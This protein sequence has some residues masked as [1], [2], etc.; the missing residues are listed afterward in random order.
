M[1]KRPR[2]YLGPR[3]Y[4]AEIIDLKT[5]E[6]RRAALANVPGDF[7]ERVAFYVQDHFDKRRSLRGTA[8]TLIHTATRR[9]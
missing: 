3:H 4:A 5:A 9:Y 2:R 7:K 8:I 6:E 1:Q